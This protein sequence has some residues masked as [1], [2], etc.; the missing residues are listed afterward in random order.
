MSNFKKKKPKIHHA[1]PTAKEEWYDPHGFQSH[2]CAE[3]YIHWLENE[4]AIRSKAVAY[5]D[6]AIR[7]L[8]DQIRNLAGWKG[9]HG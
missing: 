2:D 8:E 6:K 7:D 1:D 5:R 4:L 3:R 9:G